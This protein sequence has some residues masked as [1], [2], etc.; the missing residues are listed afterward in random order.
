[1]IRILAKEIDMGPITIGLEPFIKHRTFE[2]RI[3]SLEL[4]LAEYELEKMRREAED[5]PVT[6]YRQVLGVEFICES[7]AEMQRA[8]GKKYSKVDISDEDVEAVE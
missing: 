8:V 7:E 4:F 3:P 1:M 6:V 5:S 2:A